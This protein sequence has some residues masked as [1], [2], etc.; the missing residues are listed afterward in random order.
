MKIVVVNKPTFAE[1]LNSSPTHVLSH[2]SSSE[3]GGAGSDPEPPPDSNDDVA[4]YYKRFRFLS[5]PREMQLDQ[6]RMVAA[7]FVGTFILMF[8]VCGIISVTQLLGGQ[9]VGLLEYAATG[10]LT[11]TV[12]IFCVGPISG[13]HVNP[14]FTLA[15]AIFGHFSWYKVPFYVSAQLL[16]SMAATY[17][18]KCVYGVNPELMLTR[19]LH[20]TSGAFWIEF[21]GTYMI[22]LLA[23][24][25]LYNCKTIG[26]LSGILVG[27][28]I[29]LA[30]L[31]SGP[32]SGGSLNPARSL[33]PAIVSWEF[34]HVWI[35]IVGP[36]AG[37]ISGAMTYQF[38]RLR[39]GAPPTSNLTSSSPE[40]TPIA[41]TVAFCQV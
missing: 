1:R 28:G 11:I 24:S 7:E 35:Y 39:G 23:A 38:L 34:S 40:D 10:G 3:R 29:A 17:V 25:M 16:G 31:I 4:H 14:A 33:G 21:I 41:H 15:F 13:A 18:A 2:A 30:V 19:P 37:A 5:M 22:M 27:M 9:G 32:V 12:V 6:I 36:C 26:H 20:G 8:S